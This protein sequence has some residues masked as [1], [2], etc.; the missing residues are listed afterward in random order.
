M[1]QEFAGEVTSLKILHTWFHAEAI[2]KDNA[3]LFHLGLLCRLYYFFF[4]CMNIQE[5]SNHCQAVYRQ[6]DSLL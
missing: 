4:L 3:Y 6:S 5:E 1:E 2:G